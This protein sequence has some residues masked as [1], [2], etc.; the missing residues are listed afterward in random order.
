M[1][2]TRTKDVEDGS[3]KGIFYSIGLGPGDPELMTLKAVATIG[4]CPIVAVPDSRGSENVALAIAGAHL[5][6]KTLV[7]CDSPMV[8]DNDLIVQSHRSNAEKLAAF[9]DQGQDIAYLT[10]GDPSIYSTANYIQDHLMDM[11]Y[12]VEIIPGI[13]SFCAVAARLKQPLCEGD[14]ALHIVPAS[15]KTIDEALQLP[16][17]QVIMKAGKSIP[18]IRQAIVRQN[19][20]AVAVERCT[21]SNER[22]H[23]SLDTL[24]EQ[25]SYFSIII[26][27]ENQP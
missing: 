4:R 6:G 2:L 14:E 10:L 24:S 25:A 17:T 11:G 8:R 15:E 16:G 12:G 7:Y 5:Q 13:P 19:R 27:K 3:L 20:H 26:V 9:L 1:L 22:I 21:M 18:L 23:R